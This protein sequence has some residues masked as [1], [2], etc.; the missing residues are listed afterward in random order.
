MLVPSDN[1]I[2]RNMSCKNGSAH[3]KKWCHTTCPEVLSQVC[4]HSN[5]FIGMEE[6][7]GREADSGE[8]YLLISKL[9][10]HTQ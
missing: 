5:P 6:E 3:T 1:T 8:G 2:W 10:L 7:V 9:A 4:T